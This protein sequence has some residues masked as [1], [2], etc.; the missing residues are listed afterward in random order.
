MTLK[1]SL[2]GLGFYK[3]KQARNHLCS[4]AKE[5]VARSGTDQEGAKF[6]AFPSFLPAVS[7]STKTD[8]CLVIDIGGTST[9]AGFRSFNGKEN[10][11]LLFDEKNDELRS[12]NG[13]EESL[14]LF[15]KILGIH[16]HQALENQGLDFRTIKNFGIVWSNAMHNQPFEKGVTGFVADRDKYNKGE[17]FMAGL[18]NG[19]DLGSEFI[20]GFE[21][22]GFSVDSFI[23]AN[24]TPLTLKALPGSSSGVVVSTG[25]NATILKN[26]ADL[27]LNPKNLDL[28]VCNGEI[29][30]RF[31]IDESLLSAGDF[32]G[33]DRP[34]D[35]IEFLC[36][37]RFLPALF[38]NHLILLRSDCS[39]LEEVSEYL[40]DLGL[41]RFSEF[42]TKDLCLLIYDQKEFLKRRSQAD[43]YSEA[44]L[45]TMTEL[46]KEIFIRSASL[47][48]IVIYASIANLLDQADVFKVALDSRLGREV[49]IFWEHFL[50]SMDEL[51]LGDSKVEIELINPIACN[52]GTISVPMQGAANALDNFCLAKV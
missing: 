23:I 44:S 28:M 18:E 6:E 17:W 15:C 43:I 22:E 13:E 3:I 49:P 10:W 8:N 16:L 30:G 50:S 31:D 2:E 37:G 38:I 39:E 12:S 42:R 33:A 4:L 48:S 36:A 26:G 14:A 11:N 32:I 41:D 19:H 20:S 25:L 29:G 24:D 35:T 1:D 47:C 40:L 45:D 9:K 51:S 34:A 5:M 46:A 7:A 52:G 27:G 21:L